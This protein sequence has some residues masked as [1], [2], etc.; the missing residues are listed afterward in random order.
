MAE[1]IPVSLLDLECN[2]LI[3]EHTSYFQWVD[4]CVL[5]DY[6]WP[7]RISLE[8]FLLKN[9]YKKAGLEAGGGAGGGREL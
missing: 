1:C 6:P 5:M 9:K 4:M 2:V 8:T 7:W 3:R